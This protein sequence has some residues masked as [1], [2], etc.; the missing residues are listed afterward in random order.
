MPGPVASPGP[1][2]YLGVKA[3][4]FL[5]GDFELRPATG[6]FKTVEDKDKLT[7]DVEWAIDRADLGSL[8]GRLDS[9]AAMSA[10]F[11]RRVRE[12][13]TILQFGQASERAGRSPEETLAR[14]REIACWPVSARGYAFRVA[15][16][17]AAARTVSVVGRTSPAG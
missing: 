5:G 11:A 10:E 7:Q 15:V 3:F 9:P 2:D 16:D 14:I 12:Q 1:R 6:G 13:L 17:S 8:I 4:K